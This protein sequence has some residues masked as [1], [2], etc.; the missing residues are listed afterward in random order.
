M[1]LWMYHN[2]YDLRHFVTMGI[3]PATIEIILRAYLMIR[4]YSNHGDVKFLL[5]DN[6]KYRSMLLFAHAIA[7]AG[8]AGKIALMQG[9]PLAINYV[10]WIALLR[11]LVPSLQYWLFDKSRLRMEHMLRINEQGWSELCQSSDDLL[12]RVY[13]DTA[14]VFTLGVES[15]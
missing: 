10:E 4:H 3:T 15:I 11:Y 12:K 9:N 1:I 6:P 2:G 7:C 5:A 13:A 8:N 14:P